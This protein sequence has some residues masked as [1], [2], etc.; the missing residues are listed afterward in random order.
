M[1]DAAT[2]D[3]DVSIAVDVESL[4][5]TWKAEGGAPVKVSLFIT[6]LVDSL[7][8]QVGEAMAHLLARHGVDVE[9]PEAQTCCGQPA[10]NSGYAD[11]AREVAKTLLTAFADA[12]Y[13]VS[14]SG[15]CTGMIHHYYPSLFASEPKWA[16][17]AEELV[18]KTY[19]F[20]QFLVG[21]LGIRDV[22]A[23]FPHKVTYHA[24][25]HG[26]RL[27][28]VREEPLELLKHV[29]ELELVPLPYANDCCGFGG[30]FSVKMGHLS[31]AMV[32][33]KVRHVLE[34]EAE[35]LV[36][37]DM[38]CL[39]NIGG[40]LARAGQTVRVMHLAELLYEGVQRREQRL[41][42]PARPVTEGAVT[43]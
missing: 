1:I 34:T 2:A 12:D 36:G 11:D 17:R 5:M 20:S 26:A 8:P 25:C 35:V 27:L 4:R 38:G 3:W 39:M 30:T 40:R 10:F 6:C 23:E 37:T 29:R 28:G 7:F 32:E 21:V 41:H 19:E 15:S 9:F 13:V 22:G 33:E 16:R 24:S 42:T 31:S 43:G 14:P 18:N